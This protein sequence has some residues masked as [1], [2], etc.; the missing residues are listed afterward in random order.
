[1]SPKHPLLV[2]ALLLVLAG[3]AGK[4]LHDEGLALID[5]GNVEEGLARIEEAAK[6]EPENR[7]FRQQYIRQRDAALQ[8]YLA[9]A[10]SAKLQ[11]QWET[12]QGLYQRMLVIDKENARAKAGL[13][14]VTAER[15]QRAAL[16][17]ADALFKKGDLDRAR[18]QVRGV[19]AE[20]ANHREAQ[21]LLRRIEERALRASAGGA[22]LSAALKRPITLEFRDASLRNVFEL[23]ARNTGLNFVFDRDV[24]QDLRTTIYV[25]NTSIEDALRFVLVTSQLERKVLNENT[26]LIYP[27][28][29]A[30]QRDYQELVTKSFYLANADVKKTANMV[31][32]L[33]KTK[34]LYVD[35]DLNLLIVR[36]TPEAVRMA[37]RLVGNQDLAKPEVVLEVEVLEVGSNVLY[38]LGVRFPDQVSYS[39]VGSGGTPGTVTLPEWLNRGSDLV[40][41]TV[42]NPFLI[43]NLRNQI[44]RTNLLANPRIRV[45]NKEKA[46]IHIGD[47][48]PVITTTTTATGFLSESVTY[49]DVGLK[50]DVEPTVFLE[51]DVDIKVAL[52]VSS[53]A[54]EIRSGTG[55]LTYQVGTRNAATTL[56][57]RDGETQMLAGL[58]SDEDRKT[59]NQVPGLGEIP[60]LGRLFGSHQ[61]S[62][63]KSEIVLLITPRVVRNL[64]R[65]ELQF[66]EF[67][68]G[69]EG[70]IGAAPLMLQSVELPGG[71]SVASIVGDASGATS[72]AGAPRVL[73][74]APPAV[75]AGQEFTVQVSLEGELALRAALLDF[76]FDPSRL[77]F[78][79]AEPGALIT[80]A[81]ADAGF[82]ANAPESLGRLA[83]SISV[84]REMKGSGELARLTFQAIGPATGTPTIRLEAMSI[85][86]SAG[87]VLSAQ[88]PPPISLT[89]TR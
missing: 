76:A 89:L 44:A 48:V 9:L 7:A 77:K 87:K 61:D 56:R 72:A 85:T 58:I 41:M 4:R 50:L 5:A 51:N 59:A 16:A 62:V 18:A 21:N 24:R 15:R 19:L 53:I 12:A 49:L 11:G 82:R 68:S 70:A 45:K 14:S 25:R 43:L 78:V 57:L 42:T 30:K 32:A 40:R 86:D 67:P 10:E 74:Q 27:N 29:P 36:D 73:L 37:E 33:V 17:D 64:A 84:K 46:K 38:E 71:G 8:R 88:L 26:L 69:T 20:N 6:T 22:Q 52:E 34:D 31:K 1:M 63:N 75:A 3:C 79:R 60:I 13:E 55:T 83:L 54:R 2:L 23:I 80:G 65:P 66:E 35:E 47:K 39:I 81:G 28:T